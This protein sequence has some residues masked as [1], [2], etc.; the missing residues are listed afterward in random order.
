MTLNE[1]KAL[2]V[3]AD[4]NIKHYFSMHGSDEPYS[5]WE[6]TRQIGRVCDDRHGVADQAWRFYVHRFT[7]TEGDQTAAAIFEALDGDPRTTVRWVTDFD[8][9]SGFIHHIFEC[10]GF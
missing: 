3:S 2:L 10:E 6:E 4:P 1:I 9:D 7:K 8:K 5:Y